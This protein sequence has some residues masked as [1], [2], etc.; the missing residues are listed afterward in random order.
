M[1]KITRRFLFIQ[2]FSLCYTFIF[3]QPGNPSMVQWHKHIID[4]LFIALKSAKEDSNRV[5]ILH[6]IGF[7]YHRLAEY[8]EA[9]NY[10]NQSLSLSQKLNLRKREAREYTYLGSLYGDMGN[11]PEALRN[12]QAA[13]KIEEADNNIRGA[14]TSYNEI[15]NIYDRQGRYQDALQYLFAAMKNWKQSGNSDGVAFLSQNIASIYQRQGKYQEA[16]ENYSNAL[17][18]WKKGNEVFDSIYICEVSGAIGNVYTD[19]GNYSEALKYFSTALAIALKINK[20]VALIT[21]YRN[22]G[23]LN[24]LQGNY[25]E[26]L[27]NYLV[28]L[29][30]AERSKNKPLTAE[31]QNDI[32]NIY[33]LQDNYPEALDH[34]RIALKIREEIGDEASMIR[35]YSSIG[36]VYAKLNLFEDALKNQFAAREIS[37]RS[38]D[39]QGLII[40]NHNIGLIYNNQAEHLMQDPAKADSAIGKL[41]EALKYQYT[42]L[43]FSEETGGKFDIANTNVAIGRNFC[44]QASFLKPSNA[45]EKYSEGLKYLNKGLVLAKEIGAKELV[46]DSYSAL[47]EAYKGIDDYKNA[48]VF[49]KQYTQLKDSLINNETSK[50]IE[51]LRLKYEVEKAEAEEKDRQEE[52][53][54]EM[55]FA[56]SKREDSLKYQQRLTEEQLKQQTLIVKQN[57]QALLLKQ[58]SLDISNKQNELNQLAFLKSQAELKA[59]QIQRQ[60]KEKQLT[61]ANNERS[62]QAS[63]VKLQ[64]ARLNLKENELQA[65][66]KQRFFYIGGIALM[67]LL[68]F[69]IF[70]NIK[71]RQKVNS[72]IGAEKLRAEKAESAHKIVELELQS[73]RTQ[74]NPHFMFN[75]LNA[76]KDLILMEDN[77]NSHI[78]LSR[79]FRIVANVADNANQP[80]IPLKKEIDFLKLYL[81]MENLHIP[82]FNIALSLIYRD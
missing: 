4:S 2:L 32:G 18:H 67:L 20:A 40:S 59:E 19:L 54:T 78:Y 70:R 65:Q 14:G 29:K 12:H 10:L 31:I 26:A 6:G 24:G 33:N 44:K 50:K 15:A 41:A 72:I 51:Q 75:S 28:A 57:E 56:F 16:L 21:S 52:V 61:I 62:L 63:Q 53:Q 68:F 71:N 82:I 77:E 45:K 9:I 42:A 80:F 64:L 3:S 73:L 74:L 5:D 7:R 43:K 17:D 22:L 30:E 66:R 8:D 37:Q 34:Y 49:E 23:T 1:I 11:Y 25:P 27:R 81:S 47:S 76:I 35:L 58:A 36:S 13:L 38:G 39:K 69:F 55:K 79:F 60:E 48:F 46:K